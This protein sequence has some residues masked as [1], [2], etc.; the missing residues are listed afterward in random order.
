MT[1][2]SVVAGASYQ[3]TR[4]RTVPALPIHRPAPRKRTAASRLAGAPAPTNAM[5]KRE[6]TG[7]P[8]GPVHSTRATALLPEA[9]PLGT[10]QRAGAYPYALTTGMRSPTRMLGTITS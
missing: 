6:S 2:A 9:L 4:G 5:E 3:E 10:L 7:A 1:L 8:V